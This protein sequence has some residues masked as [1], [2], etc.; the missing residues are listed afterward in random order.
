MDANL[1]LMFIIHIF[2]EMFAASYVRMYVCII[3]WS[4]ILR[5]VYTRSNTSER[6]KSKRARRQRRRLFEYLCRGRQLS[7]DVRA[8][9]VCE[10][11]I[12]HLNLPIKKNDHFEVEW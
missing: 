3:I 1:N 4:S 10:Q 5:D 9:A 7:V 11:F 8:H 6:E 2:M 12:L